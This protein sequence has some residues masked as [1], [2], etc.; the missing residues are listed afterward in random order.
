MQRKTTGRLTFATLVVWG[1][2]RLNCSVFIRS[3]GYSLYFYLFPGK[4]DSLRLLQG[5]IFQK[6]TKLE[7]LDTKLKDLLSKLRKKAHDLSACQGWKVSELPSEQ[8]LQLMLLNTS[9]QHSRLLS[10]STVTNSIYVEENSCLTQGDVND[11]SSLWNNSL[12][13]LKYKDHKSIMFCINTF[14]NKVYVSAYQYLV[15]HW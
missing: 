1:D 7:G 8:H 3:L 12:I 10:H 11:F 14:W 9:Y 15:K 2:G 6:S 4:A 5:E 13:I